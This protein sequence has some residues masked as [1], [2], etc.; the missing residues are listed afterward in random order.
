MAKAGRLNLTRMLH[1]IAKRVL[2]AEFRFRIQ[3]PKQ[4]P[5][6]EADALESGF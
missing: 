2:S 4:R 1:E 5:T 3:S 6:Q